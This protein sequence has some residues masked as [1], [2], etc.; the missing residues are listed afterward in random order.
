M[1]HVAIDATEVHLS[2]GVDA[3]IPEEAGFSTLPCCVD[4][5]P[6]HGY[7]DS[8]AAAAEEFTA[9][10]RG[11]TGAQD[12]FKEGVKERRSAAEPEREKEQQMIGPDYRFLRLYDAGRRC[13]LPFPAR[14]KHRESEFGNTNAA[15]LMAC[16]K[17][18]IFVGRSQ[19]IPEAG[20]IGVGVTLN[21]SDFA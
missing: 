20:W 21:D 8:R 1:Q 16:R 18:A 2:D 4:S 12:L 5:W 17:R 14:P 11:E 7:D 9:I 10:L 19:R 6:T 15:N 13:S 3:A